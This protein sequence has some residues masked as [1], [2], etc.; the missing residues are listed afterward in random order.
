MDVRV[1]L[2]RRL[3]AKELMLLNCG[4]GED[5]WESL[6]QQG[7]QAVSPQGY[8][9][10]IFTGGTDEAE[11]PIIWP[12]DVKNWLTGKDPNAGKDRRQEE[13]GMTEG[14]MVG[15]HHRLDGHESE[16]APGFGDGHGSLECCSPWG[17][18]KLN[19]TE[20]LNWTNAYY[21]QKCFF[22]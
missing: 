19:T 2:Q 16:Q 7:D 1:R 11:T 13:K 15:C 6:G 21:Y 17:C 3:N 8:Q 4:V 20:L 5:S 18:K 9:S 22:I 12:H 10:W 14:K